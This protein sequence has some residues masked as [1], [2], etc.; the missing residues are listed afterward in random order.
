MMNRK[1]HKDIE[2]W[3]EAE[4]RGDAGE[5]EAAFGAAITALPRLEPRPGFAERVMY[6]FQPTPVRRFAWLSWGP[7]AATIG[8]LALI[9]VTIGL[10]PVAGVTFQVPSVGWVVDGVTG[11]IGW[12]AEW[13][14][15]GLE[16]W[17][18]MVRIGNAIGVAMTT[19]QLGAALL[20]G[21]LVS[22]AALYELNRLLVLER[23]TA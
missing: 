13:L 15:A 9:A 8:A 10:L 4:A 18:F 19:P 20:A 17:S 23:R 3:L 22:A 14:T 16:V 11:G 12:L 7:K 2:R 21:A 1:L 5:A 6:A